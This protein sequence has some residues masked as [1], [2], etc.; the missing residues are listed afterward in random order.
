MSPPASALRRQTS[1]LK[2]GQT[3]VSMAE[4]RAGRARYNQ[5][6]NSVGC[7]IGSNGQGP[8]LTWFL[9]THANPLTHPPLVIPFHTA[10]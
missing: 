5:D 9:H 1:H 3:R 4:E 6:L 2:Y 10:Q 8:W 7:H